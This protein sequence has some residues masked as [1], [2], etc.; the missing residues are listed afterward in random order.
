VYVGQDFALYFLYP[1]L[2]A[3]PVLVRWRASR[4]ICLSTLLLI[5]A[6]VLQRFQPMTVFAI[7]LTLGLTWLV[8]AW[9]VFALTAQA[10]RLRG[11]AITDPL[12]GAFN[13][14]YLELR[15]AKSLEDWARY[16]RH[17]S[18]L[19][20]DID[21]F[22]RI[23]DKFGHAVGDKALQDLVKLISQRV[24]GG[25]TL[26][27][28]GGEE[29]VLLLSEADTAVATRVA[30]KLRGDVAAA[31]ILPEGSMTISIGVCDVSC[32]T[33]V[34]HWFKLADAALYLAKSN[35]RNRVEVATTEPVVIPPRVRSVPAWR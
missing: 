23:N 34:E 27:R 10:K 35:G 20:I 15:A 16:E 29:F 5:L 4:V 31:R 12:T 2:V 25:D 11:M 30:D 18:L 19:I 13:R 9:L 6:L 8:S 14:R 24:R 26:C 32:A 21:F 7:A 3:V 17:E 28:F 22:K 33:S 1:L